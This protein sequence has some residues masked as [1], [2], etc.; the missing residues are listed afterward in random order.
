[1]RA[2]NLAKWVNAV[3]SGET[4][5]A[6]DLQ[7]SKKFPLFLTRDLQRMKDVLRK[8]TR[9]ESRHG[10]VASSGAARLRAEGLEPDSAFHARY[11]LEHWYLAGRDDVRSSFQCEVF[12]TEFEIQGLEL[13]WIGLCWGGDYVQGR[14]WLKRKFRPGPVSKWVSIKNPQKRTFRENAYRVLLT[15]ARQGLV[16]FV[17]PGDASDPTRVPSEFDSTAKYLQQ[18]GVKN[19]DNEAEPSDPLQ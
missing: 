9:G 6:A 2:E 13:D 10:L 8:E 4:Q 18:C 1:L 15:R 5:A 17:P 3:I 16:I 14:G 7:I 11:K 19:I 12:A